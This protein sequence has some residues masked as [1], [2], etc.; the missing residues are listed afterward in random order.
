M[1]DGDFEDLDRGEVEAAAARAVTQQSCLDTLPFDCLFLVSAFWLVPGLAL[2]AVGS[3]CWHSAALQG[4][5][6][7]VSPQPVSVPLR[8][9][10]SRLWSRSVG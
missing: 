8:L 6:M 9:P 5:S 4:P 7:A 2:A 3:A 1:A 10:A